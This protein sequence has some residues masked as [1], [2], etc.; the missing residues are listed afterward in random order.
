MRGYYPLPLKRTGSQ[1]TV[2]MGIRREI[3]GRDVYERTGRPD[4]NNLHKLPVSD[5]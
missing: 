3:M 4:A 2:L 5:V 1:L